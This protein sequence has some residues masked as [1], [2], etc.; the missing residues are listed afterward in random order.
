MAWMPKYPKEGKPKGSNGKTPK[1]RLHG[2]TPKSGGSKV[3]GK[4]TKLTKAGPWSGKGA[5]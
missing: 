4:G 5:K 1:A 2:A 3:G